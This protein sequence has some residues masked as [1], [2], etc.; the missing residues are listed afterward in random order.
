MGTYKTERRGRRDPK[1][2]SKFRSMVQWARIPAQNQTT[3][4][5][6]TYH[7][8]GNRRRKILHLTVKKPDSNILECIPNI[9]KFSKWSKLIRSTACVLFIR[10]CRKKEKRLYIEHTQTA[11]S[12]RRRSYYKRVSTTLLHN[13]DKNRNERYNKAV[14]S[15]PNKE[16]PRLT[17]TGTT[18]R[19]GWH[20]TD[21]RSPTGIDYF[22]PL[23]V[24]IGRTTNKDMLCYSHVSPRA[25]HLEIAASLETSS[26]IMALKG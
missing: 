4:R 25:I 9:D 8:K 5:Q 20:I 24:K 3:G 6:K 14:Y 26:A 13:T 11:T 10:L 2:T 16:R 21:A 1:R 7:F 23:T 17:S 19:T 12:R 15:V 22:G 18:S